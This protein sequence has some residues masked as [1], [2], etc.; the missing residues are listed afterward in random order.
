MQIDND[1]SPSNTRS[2]LK[3]KFIIKVAFYTPLNASELKS[4]LAYIDICYK[5]LAYHNQDNATI[6]NY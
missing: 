6:G 3:T 2:L 1:S 4:P 5:S